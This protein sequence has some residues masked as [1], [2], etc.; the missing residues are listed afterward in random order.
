MA[1]AFAN[2]LRVKAGGQH[3]RGRRMAQVLKADTRDADGLHQ[4]IEAV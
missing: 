1:K 3:E 4:P 2:D